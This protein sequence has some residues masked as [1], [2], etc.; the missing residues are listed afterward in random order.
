METK[1]SGVFTLRIV[2]AF[3]AFSY[4]LSW[5]FEGGARTFSLPYIQAVASGWIALLVVSLARNL[6]ASRDREQR[7]I[8]GDMELLLYQL[9]IWVALLSAFRYFGEWNHTNLLAGIGLATIVTAFL[10]RRGVLNITGKVVLDS[11]FILFAGIFFRSVSIERFAFGRNSDMLVL[12]GKALDA[13]LAGCSPYQVH[14]MDQLQHAYHLPLTYL[15]VKWL[16]YLPAHILSLDLRWTNVVLEACIYV[17]CVGLLIRCRR[18]NTQ[19]LVLGIAALNVYFMNG[20]FMH[21]IDAEISV[22]C[23]LLTVIFALFQL[24]RE[25]AAYLVLG[26]ALATSQLTLL[27]LPFLVPRTIRDSNLRRGLLLLGMSILLAL[28]IVLPFV[29]Q[30]PSG[31]KA[32]L[33]DHWVSVAG[34]DYSWAKGAILNLNFSVHFFKHGMQEWLKYLQMALCATLWG[35]FLLRKG[36]TR[37]VDVWSFCMLTTFSFLMFNIIVWT[38]LFQPVVLLAA[39]SIFTWS[40]SEIEKAEPTG[41]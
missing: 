34:K 9:F 17:M 3:L 36:Y 10:V 29:L 40:C 41:Q 35:F 30:N 14:I 24:K 6:V 21:R 25:I 2:L 27:L 28:T 8:A 13:F 31:F 33:V 26:V 11:T 7:H 18:R 1:I 20:Y 39:F 37:D 16:A 12:V 15:P 38:Y 19:A 5:M 23:F 4:Y 22:Y 32:G